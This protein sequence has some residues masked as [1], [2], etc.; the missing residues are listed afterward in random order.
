MFFSTYLP[1]DASLYHKISLLKL[2]QNVHRNLL[3]SSSTWA[4]GKYTFI[5]VSVTKI[6]ESPK[7]C[8]ATYYPGN[9]PWKH[10]PVKKNCH[11]KMSCLMN[12]GS[13]FSTRSCGNPKV[14]P[15]SQCLWAHFSPLYLIPWLNILTSVKNLPVC[16]VPVW[17]FPPSSEMQI[18]TRKE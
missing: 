3:N 7:E 15:A 13:W 12:S 18:A 10:F 16:A 11:E 8:K 2:K 1:H 6:N 14:Q 5:G 17:H 9:P 4:I